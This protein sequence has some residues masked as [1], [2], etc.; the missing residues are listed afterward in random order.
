MLQFFPY[1]EEFERVPVVMYS[2]IIATM[3][4]FAVGTWGYERGRGGSLLLTGAILFY[5]S[6]TILAAWHVW[7]S[8]FACGH[9]CYLLYYPGVALLASAIRPYAL[10]K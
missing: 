3:M 10:K 9:F 7:G 8:E 6:D 2:A 1:I 4:F 5:I